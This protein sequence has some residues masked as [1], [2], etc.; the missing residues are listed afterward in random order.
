[1]PITNIAFDEPLLGT[2]LLAGNRFAKHNFET[3]EAMKLMSSAGTSRKSRRFSI[4]FGYIKGVK[5]N[6]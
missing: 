4:A 6:F 5:I 1:M 2:L 3:N